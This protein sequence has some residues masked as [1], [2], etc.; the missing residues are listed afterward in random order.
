MQSCGVIRCDRDLGPI[1]DWPKSLVPLPECIFQGAV[2][3]V[4]PD[5][6]ET[7][8]S[9]PVPSHLLLLHHSFADNLV[10]VFLPS[11]WPPLLGASPLSRIIYA[12]AAKRQIHE[13]R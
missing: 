2:Q 3:H 9:V 10:V 6:E 11:S 7:L 12:A 8:D 4:N 1:R 13:S 5:V